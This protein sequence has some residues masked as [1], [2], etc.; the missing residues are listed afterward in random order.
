MQT[1]TRPKSTKSSKASLANEL[2][3]LVKLV[4]SHKENIPSSSIALV[5]ILEGIT[6]D[7]WEKIHALPEFESWLGIPLEESEGH[8]ITSLYR[9][10]ET[11][12]FERDHDPLTGIGNR[13]LFDS[14]IENEIEREQRT[15]S[16][17]S[18][19]SIDIDYFK[20][21]N[22][23]YGHSVGDMVLKKLG[24]VL[25]Q[26]ARAYDTPARIGGE[27]FVLL[28]P[29]VS[30]MTATIVAR[31]MLKTFSEITFT[32]EG[33]SFNVTFSAG[34]SSIKSLQPPVNAKQLLEVADKLLYLAKQRG[35][36]RV[37]SCMIDNA[38][39]RSNSVVHAEE[40]Q[41]LFG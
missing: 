32:H 12:L 14:I 5:R 29:A 34:V 41:L 3:A 21:I 1:K 8:T 31:R 36:N 28:L 37:C 22:D 6:K 4:Y 16:D 2:E 7:E 35:R 26:A 38:E 33:T 27:E 30:C 17:L 25:S 18:I 23:T 20:K 13:R 24:E 9:Y 19:I 15:S 39:S 40:K 10:I 11:L